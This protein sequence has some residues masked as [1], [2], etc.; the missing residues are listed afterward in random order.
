M[1]YYY[2]V[3]IEESPYNTTTPT[4]FSFWICGKKKTNLF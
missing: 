4:K 2:K 3:L 1:N